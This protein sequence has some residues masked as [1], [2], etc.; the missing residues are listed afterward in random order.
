MDTQELPHEDTMVGAA[1]ASLKRRNKHATLGT[2]LAMAALVVVAGC[3]NGGY[4]GR[5]PDNPSPYYPGRYFTG[6]IYHGYYYGG[7][8]SI[9]RSGFGHGGGGFGGSGSGFGHGGGGFGGG[10]RGH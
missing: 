6:G 3:P 7:H 2:L 8:H 4:Y 1:Q 9:G 10:G 5:S